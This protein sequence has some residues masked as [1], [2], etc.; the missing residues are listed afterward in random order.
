MTYLKSVT[1]LVYDPG[2]CTGCGRCIEVCPREVFVM[3]DK[4]AA[5]TDKDRCMEC[6][7]CALNC[8]FGAIT[9]N[10]GVGCAAAV[11]HS[12]LK[13]GEPVCGCSSESSA[14]NASCC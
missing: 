7:A 4:K 12:I 6:G 10:A 14:G 9:V 3:R 2:K 5:V 11:I 13:G 1:T 8:E